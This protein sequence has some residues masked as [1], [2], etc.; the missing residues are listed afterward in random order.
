M[1]GEVRFYVLIDNYCLLLAKKK[2]PYIQRPFLNLQIYFSKITQLF[3]TQL[4]TLC[5][6]FF[7]NGCGNLSV[8]F[9]NTWIEVTSRA[10]LVSTLHD[11]LDDWHLAK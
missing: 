10:T 8:V 3:S 6:E 4:L 11:R 5:R 7:N 1:M 9:F 2:R